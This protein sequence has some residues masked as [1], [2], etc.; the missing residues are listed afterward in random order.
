VKE[1]FRILSAYNVPVGGGESERIW[2][3]S[4]ADRSITTILL[5]QEY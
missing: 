3:I 1:G 2:I 5:T 4:E